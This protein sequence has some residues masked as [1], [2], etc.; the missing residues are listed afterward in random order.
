MG[1]IQWDRE[2]GKLS[3]GPN[4]EEIA[5]LLRVM[6]EHRNELPDEWVPELSSEDL[7]SSDS[8]PITV[9]SGKCRFDV[10]NNTFDHK[11][12]ELLPPVR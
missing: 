5:P 8:G 1:F 7:S 10:V 12:T 4:W 9:P 2:L 11:L 6:H 3:T